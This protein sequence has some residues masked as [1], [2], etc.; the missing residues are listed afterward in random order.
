MLLNVLLASIVTLGIAGYLVPT[1][2]LAVTPTA[3]GSSLPNVVAGVQQKWFGIA[4]T[5][6]G[7]GYWVVS[8]GG[9]VEP[10]GDAVSYGDVAKTVLNQ[11]VVGMAPT[12]DGRGYW[13]D[14]ADGGIFSFG[15][16]QFRGSTGSMRLNEPVV[17]M[18]PTHA[19][20][21][22]WLVASD[23]GIF[24]FGDAPFEGSMGA[25][26]LN[27]PVVGM[28]PTHDGGG[29]WMVA[30]DGGIFAFGDAPFEG[31]LG[32]SPPTS[33]ISYMA[34]TPDNNG[35]WLVSQDGAV[36]AFGDAGNYGS[37][38]G[39]SAPAT[40]L[41]AT[42]S[43]GYWVLTADGAVHPFGDAS[44]YG[45]P[46][47]GPVAALSPPNLPAPSS[48]SGSSG[49]GNAGGSVSGGPDPVTI[50]GLTPSSGTAG[51]GDA[52]DIS[53]SGFT[54]ATA[55]DFGSNASSDFTVT[56]ATSITAVAPVGAGVVDV[57]GGDAGG[58]VAAR[59][60]P[61]DSPTY[62]PD[63]CPSRRRARASRSAECP[64]CSPASTPISWPPTG[65]PM[66]V[67][68]AWP[69]PPRST[70]SSAPSAPIPSCGSGP[71]RDR[72]RRTSIRASWTGAP[73]DNVF[74]EAAKYHVY[75]IPT[76]SDQAGTC[77]GG[78]WQDPAWY[79]GGF[80]DVYNSADNSDGR[81]LAPLSYWDY[82]NALVSRYADS[83]A[84]GMWEPMSEAEASTCPAAFEP[85]N[86]EGHQ[87]CPD[88]AA[89][90]TALEYF[91]T[92]VGGHN[93]P[94]RPRAPR[95]SRLSRWRAVRH[96]R[97]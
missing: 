63:N 30:S 62:R 96:G 47:T 91:F 18:A 37:V 29:Y 15:D 25:H 55:V 74:Y 79:S 14:A 45:S 65:G 48:P 46:A 36:H 95:R 88:Q 16:A 59:A 19:G 66:P 80:K 67:A 44:N 34:P 69:P 35:Y 8:N 68:A 87:T 85:S 11:P 20:D 32:G 76:I 73:L 42:P 77:D 93:P 54:G 61:L 94:P 21:G 60:A 49:S 6:D 27:K 2:A 50:S 13:L 78:H 86:C 5:R 51:G 57:A 4:G 89:A 70:R 28:V 7:A 84:L 39:A 58:H 75:L 41:A 71:S 97:H 22:Y 72:W 43:G 1:F 31:S 3:V 53:G 9:T 52:I 83:P 64:P 92:T 40:S 56:S 17:G 24:A 10:F 38:R 26:H 82:M 33:P 12:P 90:A 23:G 81:G